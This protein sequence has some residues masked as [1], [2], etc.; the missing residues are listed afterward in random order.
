LIGPFHRRAQ[1]RLQMYDGLL[2][3]TVIEVGMVPLMQDV[4]HD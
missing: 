4:K 2:S 1:V 3:F